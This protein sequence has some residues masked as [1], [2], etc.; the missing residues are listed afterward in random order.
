MAMYEF[1]GDF[2]MSVSEAGAF[3]RYIEPLFMTYM[4]NTAASVREMG[5]LKVSEMSKSLHIGTDWILSSFVSRCN[6][7]YNTDQ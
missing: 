1:L 7:I 6:Q 4:T 5:A 3:E 2:A